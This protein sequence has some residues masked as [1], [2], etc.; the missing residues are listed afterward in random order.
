MSSMKDKTIAQL[1]REALIFKRQLRVVQARESLTAFAHLMMPDV[2][3]P[4]DAD[5]T[6]YQQSAPAACLCDLVEAIERGDKKRVAVAMPPQHGKT[7]HL[8]IY[9]VA[10]ILGRNP[11]AKIVVVTYNETRAKD[12]GKELLNLFK[13]PAYKQCFPDLQ[14][15]PMAQSQSFIQNMKGGRITLTGIGG[16]ITGKTA[17]FF[18]IDDPIKGEDDESDLTPTALE[19]LWTWFFKV[20]YSRGSNKTRMLITH[21][22]WSEDDLIGRLCDPSHPER[23]KRF[24]GIAEDW[25]YL[26]LPA[27]IKDKE[28]ADL[29]GL[30]LERPTDPKVTEMFG[31]EPMVAL[32]ASNKNLRFFA[33]W[34]R[35]DPLSFSALAMGA[36]SPENG[37]YFLRDQLVEYQLADLPPKERLRF[38]GASDHAVT[39]KQERDPN[40]IGCVGIDEDDNIWVM[41]D[42]VWERMETDRVVEEILTSMRRKKPEVWWAE[43]DVIR[44]AFGP[45]LIKRMNEEKVFITIDP[46]RPAQDKKTRARS[47]QGRIAMKKVFFPAFAPWWPDAKAELL[48]FPRGAH[49]DFVDWLALFGLG[50]MKEQAAEA[51][52]DKEDDPENVIRTGSIQWILAQTKRKIEAEKKHKRNAGW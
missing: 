40:V 30:K 24:K 43:D 36:P 37:T 16:T 51:T 17:D 32:W 10:W 31:V 9:G 46:I 8:S 33:E 7:V 1:Q 27:V 34:K 48:K 45:F 19:R 49:D 39:T 15:D 25:F 50:L 38:Y 11:R 28:L 29:L 42:L 4:D 14:L 52:G 44:K 18:F 23:K 41:P 47:I 2:T 13:S 35:G 12:L 26:N 22:R 20:A 6:E 5:K 21:T 3:D